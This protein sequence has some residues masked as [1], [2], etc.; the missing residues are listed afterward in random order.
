MSEWQPIST[1]PKDSEII[2]T[3]GE[4][5][6]ITQWSR[7]VSGSGFGMSHSEESFYDDMH[8][9]HWKRIGKLPKIEEDH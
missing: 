5:A 7:Y 1:A 4:F 3:D 6:F 9:T 2:A 8:P